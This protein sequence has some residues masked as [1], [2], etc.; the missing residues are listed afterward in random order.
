VFIL[1]LQFGGTAFNLTLCMLAADL[2]AQG[3][4]CT[5]SL[6]P[7]QARQHVGLDLGSILFDSHSAKMRKKKSCKELT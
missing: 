4:A 2:S 1:S 5:N 3:M 6:D 7:D